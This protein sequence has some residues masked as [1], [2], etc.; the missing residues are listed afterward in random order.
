MIIDIA[1]G[2]VLAVL[3]LWFLPA[4][5]AAGI[6]ALFLALTAGIILLTILWLQS[7]ERVATA[8]IVISVPVAI[9]SFGNIIADLVSRRTVFTQAE[10]LSSLTVCLV[11]GFALLTIT[12][13]TQSEIYP[14]LSA[15]LR[16]V[17]LPTLF[18]WCIGVLTVLAVRLRRLIL[19]RS[20]PDVVTEA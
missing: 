14:P 2:I 10:I 17:V 7:N 8:A 16:L 18:V 6:I 3:I 4:I 5:I 20:Q 19:I 13:M 12:T 1:L 15:T 11:I 9:C